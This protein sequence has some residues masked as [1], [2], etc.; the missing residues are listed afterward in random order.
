VV[1]RG[2]P[3]LGQRYLRAIMRGFSLASL[4]GSNPDTASEP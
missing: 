3:T 2:V 1:S 4:D